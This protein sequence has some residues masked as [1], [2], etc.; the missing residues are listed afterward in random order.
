MIWSI[1]VSFH[2]FGSFTVTKISLGQFGS[3]RITGSIRVSGQ[4]GSLA[5]PS[6]THR[7]THQI[8]RLLSWLMKSRDRSLGTH[9]S[10]KWKKWR[11]PCLQHDVT[12][13]LVGRIVVQ[14]EF[15]MLILDCISRLYNYLNNLHIHIKRRSVHSAQNDFWIGYHG[16]SMTLAV[17]LSSRA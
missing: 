17:A 9:W 3:V 8:H 4:F 2:Y 10:I 14:Y 13:D 11:R 15:I 12:L 16:N 7:S 6:K 5:V 1:K